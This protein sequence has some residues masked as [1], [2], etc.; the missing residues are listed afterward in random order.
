LGQLFQTFY[1]ALIGFV[2]KVGH[3]DLRVFHELVRFVSR[4]IELWC[5][6]MYPELL[7]SPRGLCGIGDWGDSPEYLSR[8]Q[9]H[10]AF[11]GRK[12][13]DLMKTIRFKTFL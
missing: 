4:G 10:E 5:P 3:G 1:F 2:S 6:E 12:F 11:N 9:A 7:P 13:L 8:G